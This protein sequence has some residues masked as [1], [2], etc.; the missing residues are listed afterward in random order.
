MH[1]AP[2]ILG[3]GNHMTEITM[4]Q[5]LNDFSW[6]GQVLSVHNIGPYG[7][8]EYARNHTT[9]DNK[10]LPRQKWWG[11]YI[12]GE[13][14]SRSWHSLDAALAGLITFRADGPNSQAADYFI[15]SLN[16]GTTCDF[17][18]T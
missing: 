17:E 14:Q 13:K 10:D 12:N 4:R 16:G 15:K 5:A 8:V 9:P 18:E 3:K 11:G 7:V 6:L 1:H 2:G